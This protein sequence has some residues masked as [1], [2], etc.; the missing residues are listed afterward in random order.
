ML[1]FSA[2]AVF[3]NKRFVTQHNILHHP[4]TRP[5][6]LYNIDGFINKAGSL[7]H[8]THLTM[9]IDSKYTEKLNFLIMDLGPEDIILGFSWLH[10]I[11]SEV[12]WDT[13]IMEL[14][15]SLKPDPLPNDSLF[16]KISANHATHH[17]WIKAGIISETTNELWCCAGF[18]PSAKKSHPDLAI[19]CYI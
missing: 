11:N 7:T 12:N 4:L 14:P 5:I 13:G 8:F 1:D 3:I 18:T 15:D 2:M 16:E 17:I 10:Q 6:A 19:F 9:N